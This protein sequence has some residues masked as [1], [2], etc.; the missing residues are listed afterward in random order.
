MRVVTVERFGMV[1]PDSIEHP[2]SVYEG[3]GWL[4]RFVTQSA[5]MFFRAELPNLCRVLNDLD[6]RAIYK[7]ALFGDGTGLYDVRLYVSFEEPPKNEQIDQLK[8]AVSKADASG[9]DDDILDQRL[10]EF[11]REASRTAK[12]RLAKALETETNVSGTN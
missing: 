3:D 12:R 11:L 6:V 2:G 9:F 4:F 8:F 5:E 10:L 7:L 1:T